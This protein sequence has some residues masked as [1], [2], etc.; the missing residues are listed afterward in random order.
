M[1]DDSSRAS[2]QEYVQQD[3]KPL[4]LFDLLRI[5][6]TAGG[7]LYTQ[8]ALHSELI[9]LD[10]AEEK[11]RLQR[12]LLFTLL[13]VVCLLCAM[14]F[15]GLLILLLTWDTSFRLPSLLV[16][17]CLYALGTFY[18]WRRFM[19]L[20]AQSDNAFAATKKEIAADISVLRSNL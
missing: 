14:L 9:K 15:S 12:M 3:S 6:R 8:A 2:N 13:G 18:A 19:T 17:I 5:L 7:A 4:T 20:S 1:I 10:L 11:F 16:L